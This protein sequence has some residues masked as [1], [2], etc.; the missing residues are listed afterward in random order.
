MEHQATPAIEETANAALYALNWETINAPIPFNGR[1]VIHTLRRPLESTRVGNQI[2]VSESARFRSM[3][4]A[5]EVTSAGVTTISRDDADA[6]DW[7]WQRLV[8]RV[9]GYEG[10][11]AELPLTDEIKTALRGRHK[12]IAITALT[13]FQTDIIVEKSESSFSGELTCVRAWQGR[14]KADDTYVGDFY[15][16]LWSEAQRKAYKS[17]IRATQ[18]R[19]GKDTVTTYEVP[20]FETAKLY[21]ALIERA[22][23]V[24]IS[25]DAGT[26][27]AERSDLA[28]HTQVF[29]KEAVM[30]EC[31]LHWERIAGN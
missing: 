10:V 19:R 3:I 12:E 30:A 22:D 13:D 31:F 20:L 2:G 9:T 8:V 4:R 29:L 21:D 6:Y 7:L 11:G 23:G 16:N 26:R 28:A 27:P 1:E 17:S 5:E 18:Q 15:V 14:R 25:E 24:G